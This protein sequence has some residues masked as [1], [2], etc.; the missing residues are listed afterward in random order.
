MSDV[1][2]RTDERSH[3]Q[4]CR[5]RR[6]LKVVKNAK[7]KIQQIRAAAGKADRN[8]VIPYFSA[9][10]AFFLYYHS[11]EYSTSNFLLQLLFHYLL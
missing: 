4:G 8:R 9:T 5:G 6:I 3:V 2:T 11:S 10:R 7:E 1:K